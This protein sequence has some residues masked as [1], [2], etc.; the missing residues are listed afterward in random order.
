MFRAVASDVNISTLVRFSGFKLRHNPAPAEGARR[1]APPPAS[2]RA[3][4]PRLSA[5]EA[6]GR[7]QPTQCL[8]RGG[9]TDA[10]PALYFMAVGAARAVGVLRSRRR[11]LFPYMLGSRSFSAVVLFPSFLARSQCSRAAR[12]SPP[13]CV[14][15]RALPR[16]APAAPTN[17][18]RQATGL[19]A[20]DAYG[21][22]A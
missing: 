20:R 10:P 13:P 16:S 2:L 5:R 14:G 7:G 17:Y 3:G 4:L 18:P 6:R 22:L 12:S 9:A 19:T 15:F 21:H 11:W 8:E 1:A